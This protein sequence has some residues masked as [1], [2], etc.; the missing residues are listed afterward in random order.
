MSGRR[1]HDGPMGG[2]GAL[3]ATSRCSVQTPEHSLGGLSD[4]EP[5]WAKPPWPG[6]G[7]RRARAAPVPEGGSCAAST[8][9]AGRNTSCG[10]RQHSLCQ[11]ITEPVASAQHMPELHGTQPHVAWTEMPTASWVSQPT[12]PTLNVYQS[13]VLLSPEPPA[14]RG[15]PSPRH[16]QGWGACRCMLPTA[17]KGAV[18]YLVPACPHH[19]HSRPGG[20]LPSPSP[21]LH[22]WWT[23]PRPDPTGWRRCPVARGR[24]AHTTG[25]DAPASQASCLKAAEPLGGHGGQWCYGDNQVPAPTL[26][27]STGCGGPLP[28]P[29]HFHTRD[30]EPCLCG[31]LLMRCHRHSAPLYPVT[32]GR[33]RARRSEPAGTEVEGRLQAT[34]RGLHVCGS[35]TGK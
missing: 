3:C 1:L 32:P 2:R 4:L 25:R 22:V 26:M 6:S 7:E 13:H 16:R 30:P 33:H 31:T 28:H 10:F 20:A 35:T 12:R 27:W 19:R 9:V 29:L 24:C 34:C 8:A 5:L 17:G 18:T 14:A 15:A 11:P 21:N 23:F